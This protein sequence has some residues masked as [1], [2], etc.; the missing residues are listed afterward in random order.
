MTYRKPSNV[1]YV[2]MA[3]Y[4]DDHVYTDDCDDVLV[5]KYIYFLISMLAYQAQYFKSA[6]YYDDFAL[7]GASRVFMRLRNPKQFEVDENGKPRMEKIRSVLNYIKTTIYPM[8][9]DFEQ[10]NYI[11][12]G[13]KDVSDLVYDSEV[14]F[15]ARINETV[16]ELSLVDFEVYLGEICRT[17][18]A[19][20]VKIPRKKNSCEWLNIYT[21][22]VLTLLNSVTLSEENLAKIKSLGQ[23]FFSKP[24][25]IDKMYREERQNSVILYHLP[26]EMHDYILVLT[27]R[28]RR[29]IAR[30]LSTT[31]RTYVT[32]ESVSK[33][34]IMAAIEG[35]EEEDTYNDGD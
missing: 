20:L 4:I 19:F 26:E 17:I 34:M 27:N 24:Y 30:D 11:Q 29:I 31:L 18:R 32:G 14:D 7:S 23:V 15:R 1:K 25:L 6:Q 28:L 35:R 12:N 9:V 33:G 10:E 8:K 16:D 5:F 3:K 13:I 21:S 22:C 2:D